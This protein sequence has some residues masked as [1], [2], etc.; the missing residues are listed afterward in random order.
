MSLDDLVIPNSKDAIKDY[1]PPVKRT[2]NHLMRLY[3]PEIEQ[4][5]HQ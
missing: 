3:W 5:E 1:Q 4:S 2:Q